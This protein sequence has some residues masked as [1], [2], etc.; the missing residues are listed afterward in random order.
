MEWLLKEKKKKEKK[1]WQGGHMDFKL[2]MTA[3]TTKTVENLIIKTIYTNVLYMWIFIYS[4]EKI[5]C[6]EWW[7][8]GQWWWNLIYLQ[9]KIYL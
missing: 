6:E 2:M 4:D 9:V 8:C 3:T 1:H 7:L 5:I